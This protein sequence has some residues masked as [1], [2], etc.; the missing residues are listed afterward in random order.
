M[1]MPWIYTT[2]WGVLE[3]PVSF[4]L[5][6]SLSLYNHTLPLSSFCLEMSGPPTRSIDLAD[7]PIVS[8]AVSVSCRNGFGG[9]CSS[10][11]VER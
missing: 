11:P 5:H 10:Y 1:P 3:K 7:V 9:Q 2:E 6:L 4:D 8:H